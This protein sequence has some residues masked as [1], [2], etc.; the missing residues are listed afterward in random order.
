MNTCVKV[1]VTLA[2]HC[3][4]R[5]SF[6]SRRFVDSIFTYEIGHIIRGSTLVTLGNKVYIT[7]YYSNALLVHFR[8]EDLTL[9]F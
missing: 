2:P 8:V 1:E 3:H 4:S 6:P 7:I 9:F 5:L